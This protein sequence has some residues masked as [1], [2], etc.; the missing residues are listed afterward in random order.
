MKCTVHG[1]QAML[2]DVFL[3]SLNKTYDLDTLEA[4]VLEPSVCVA[5]G[6]PAAKKCSLL[7]CRLS[8]GN[9]Y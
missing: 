2:L 5:C 3:H 8:T 9:T 1:I 6:E 7:G 4:L